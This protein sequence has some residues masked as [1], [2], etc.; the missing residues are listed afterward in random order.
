MDPGKKS[1]FED[2]P[3]YKVLYC[4]KANFSLWEYKLC[5]DLREFQFIKG[6]V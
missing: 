2:Y 1:G 3:V 4:I 5:L 6:L